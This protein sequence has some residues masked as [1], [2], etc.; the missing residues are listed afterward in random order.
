MTP[1]ITIV[2][3]F[4]YRDNVEEWSN[5]YHFAGATPATTSD[6]K[7]LADAIIAEEKTIVDSLVSF[8]RAYGYTAD[9][10]PSV[11]TIDYTAAPLTPVHGTLAVGGSFTPGDVAMTCRWQTDRRT[12]AGKPIYLRKY[13]HAAQGLSTDRDMLA[14]AQHTALQ[15]FAVAM[16]SPLG[17]GEQ[18]MSGPDGVIPHSPSASPWL[19]TRT[20]KRRGKRPPS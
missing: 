15:A 8:V 20:L 12:S 3:S 7:I 4:T 17:V 19:T 1:S 5:R 6:W 14:T 13:F 11:A 2:A 9:G 18:T 10:T 16:L